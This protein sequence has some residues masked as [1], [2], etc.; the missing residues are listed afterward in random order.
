MDKCVSGGKDQ[1]THFSKQLLHG[2]GSKH[3]GG[4]RWYDKTINFVVSEDGGV[5]MLYEHSPA[6]GQPVAVMAD[7]I[8]NC[9]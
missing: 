2:F 5:G 7:Y 8:V 3:N 4:N 6:E 9:L 1:L